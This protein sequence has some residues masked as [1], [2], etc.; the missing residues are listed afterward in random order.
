VKTLTWFVERRLD[1][2][3]FR[4]VT[5]GFVNRSHLQETFGISE[6]QAS[7]TLQLFLRLYPGAMW[8]DKTDKHYCRQLN[9]YTS[10]RGMTPLV[11]RSIADLAI[12]GH[13]MGWY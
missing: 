12:S 11:I 9:S 8:Y 13:P 3:D 10:R 4:L 5:A 1:Y 2:V 7:A 6:M